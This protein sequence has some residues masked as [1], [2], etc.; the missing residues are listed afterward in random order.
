MFSWLTSRR[1]KS[2]IRSRRP[3]KMY[4][5][6]SRLGME[7]LEDRRLLAVTTSDLNSGLTPADLAQSLVGAGV[8][9]SNVVYTGSPLAGGT[10]AGG[11][12]DGLGIESGVVLSSGNIVGAAG[13]NDADNTSTSFGTAG[14]ADLN[15][16]IPGFNTRDAS[17]LEFDFE[18][19]G[20]SISFQYVFASEEYNEYVNSSYND[21]F[22]F[23]LDGVNIA[24][25][26]GTSTPVSINNVNNG[27]NSTHYRDNDPSDLGIP[28]PFGTEADGF[29]AVL[30]ASGTISVGTHHIKLAI[31]DAGDTSLNSWV[32]LAGESFVSTAADLEITKSDSPDPVP[33]GTTLTYTLTVT[34]NGP[35]EATLVVAQ[36][37]L[38]TGVA[39]VS[40]AASQGTVD[41]SGGIVTANVGTLASGVSATVTIQVTPTTSGTITNTATVQAAQFDVDLDNNLVTQATVVQDFIPT[42]VLGGQGVW[43]NHAD[44]WPVTSLTI[45]GISYTKAELVTVLKTPPKGDAVLILVHQLIA[46]KLNV[47]NGADS[48]SI[49]AV[50]ADA[51]NLLTGINLLSHS[52]VKPSSALGKQMTADS[53]LLDTFNNSL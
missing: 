52:T 26:P 4:A 7:C 40:A 31:A 11:L 28:T 46:A 29:T 36:D 42:G 18:V 14:D 49:A 43:K 53:G 6:H 23:F 22:G 1:P 24:L 38:P 20:G 50:I 2:Q 33:I 13:P 30:Q 45:G 10:F 39:F 19:T 25:L 17:I 15:G 35:D 37:T 12:S 27:L 44:L 47:L 32:F 9:V 21:V 48:T 34:N 16:L 5:R 8:S 3:I 51:D 41:E